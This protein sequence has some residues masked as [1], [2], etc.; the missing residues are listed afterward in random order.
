MKP[1]ERTVAGEGDEE[2]LHH[3][4]LMA[5]LHDLVRKHGGRRG[6]AG[7]LGIDRRTVA[8]CMDGRGMSW[9]MREALERGTPG[10]RGLCCRPAAEA[11]RCAGAAGGGVGEGASRGPRCRQRRDREA[12]G[13][14]GPEMGVVGA[15]GWL[16]GRHRESP[17]GRLTCWV[18]PHGGRRRPRQRPGRRRPASRSVC[19]PSW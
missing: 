8:A 11:Q 6:A 18:W 13:G 7:V 9:R 15:G 2:E 16:A 3:D 19:T 4:R 17:R 12:A 10:G 5:L 14:R 1:D